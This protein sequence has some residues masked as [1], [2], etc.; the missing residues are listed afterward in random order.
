MLLSLNFTIEVHFLQE[1]FKSG[2]KIYNGEYVLS[3][4]G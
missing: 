2:D 4:K 1:D 3:I